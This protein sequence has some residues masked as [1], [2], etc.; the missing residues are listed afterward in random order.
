MWT[1]RADTSGSGKCLEHPTLQHSNTPH[2]YMLSSRG[3][4]INRMFVEGERNSRVGI[5]LAG[6]FCRGH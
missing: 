5:R 6:G 3:K 2:S 1:S 4:W